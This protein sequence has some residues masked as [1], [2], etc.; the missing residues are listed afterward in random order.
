M[1]RTLLAAQEGPVADP[2]EKSDKLSDPPRRLLRG[3]SWLREAK[4]CRSAARYRN[5]PGSR[6]ADNGFRIVAAEKE[7][8]R[9]APA[10]GG[11]FFGSPLACSIVDPCW[12][13]AKL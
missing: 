13:R 11:P 5:T 8:I 6:N 10:A 1:T 3:G 9:E 4:F 7:P 2:E 12:R